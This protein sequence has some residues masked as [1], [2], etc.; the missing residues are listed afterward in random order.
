MKAVLLTALA[1]LAF[2]GNSILCRMALGE[3]S[4]D[5]GSFTSIRLISGILTLLFIWK[6]K[7]GVSTR[8]ESVRG[9]WYAAAML[10]VYAL[11]FSY[12]YIALDTGTG[13]LIL[14]ASV[15]LTIILRSVLKGEKLHVAEWL[16]VFIAFAGFI[17][18]V[19]PNVSTP[20]L[21]GFVLMSVSGIAWGFYTLAGKG[22]ENPLADTTFNFFRTLPLAL[23][24]L[25]L[26][27]K[28]AALSAEGVV[29]A[30]VAGSVTSGIG[31]TI[32]YM[33]LRDISA[34]QASVVQLLVPVIAAI[35]GWV[36]LEEALSLRL[37]LASAAI[38]FGILMVILARQKQ[39]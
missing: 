30:V 11:T 27:F 20:S 31:Y 36:F 16:G 19:I 22:S 3:A 14:F 10:F 23:L 1:L 35:S 12:A 21:T 28:F 26:T 13:A 4:I 18:L 34:L 6:I 29:L 5:A 2:A 17:Y 32:W 25:A 15:Q 7:G 37:A 8:A 24:C 9:S 39:S 33:A 38:L